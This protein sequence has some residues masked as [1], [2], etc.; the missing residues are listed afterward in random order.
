MRERQAKFTADQLQLQQ[1][2]G[3]LG[4]RLTDFGS[5][6]LR[7]ANLTKYLKTFNDTF[8]NWNRDK[9]DQGAIRLTFLAHDRVKGGFAELLAQARSTVPPE[10]N[11]YISGTITSV[12]QLADGLVNGL[13][14]GVTVSVIVMAL[15]CVVLF[16]SVRLAAIAAGPNAFPILVV[17]GF[18]GALGI[19]ITSGSAMVATV[20]IGMNQTIYF[21]M[22][23][24]KLTRERGMNTDTA[25]H[26]AFVKIGRPV[27]LTSLVFTAGFLIFLVSDFLPLY[28]FGLLTSIAMFAGMTGDVVL[29]P[30]LLRTFDRVPSHAPQLEELAVA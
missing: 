4:Q 10:F 11:G 19:P 15:V 20:S 3:S 13:A 29:L 26:E 7:L 6:M 17:Y 24:R 28:H 18:M 27:V 21:L 23:Y 5:R 22:R 12:V 9:L 30:C 14:W 25:L 2:G 1:S 8:D 16:R